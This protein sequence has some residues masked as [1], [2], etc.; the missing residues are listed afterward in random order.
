MVGIRN[1]FFKLIQHRHQFSFHISI[2]IRK[3]YKRGYHHCYRHQG[4]YHGWPT[5]SAENGAPYPCKPQCIGK[6]Q[7]RCEVHS[8]PDT[9]IA[10]SPEYPPLEPKCFF[11][12]VISGCPGI[13]KQTVPVREQAKSHVPHVKSIRVANGRKI[14]IRF[15]YQGSA[16]AAETEQRGHHEIPANHLADARDGNDENISDHQFIKEHDSSPCL[17]SEEKTPRDTYGVTVDPVA[18][19]IYPI[20]PRSSRFPTILRMPFSRRSTSSQELYP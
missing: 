3:L 20:T 2:L 14:N 19:R 10:I 18:C 6:Y 4:Q 13:G 7:Q 12:S 5:V 16:G 15:P 11:A 17:H 8:S 9:H 1:T